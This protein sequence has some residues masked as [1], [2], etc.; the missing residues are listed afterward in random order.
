MAIDKIYMRRSAVRNI[1]LSAIGAYPKETTGLVLL[2]DLGDRNILLDDVLV[3]PGA[4][5]N[6]K[7]SSFSERHLKEVLKA[8][9]AGGHD[10]IRSFHS[11]TA[12]DGKRK[13]YLSDYPDDTGDIPYIQGYIKHVWDEEELESNPWIEFLLWIEGKS[14]KTRRKPYWSFSEKENGFSISVI[15]EQTGY[16]MLLRVFEF[17]DDGS[18]YFDHPME[19]V[20]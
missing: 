14:Y 11:H 15:T 7:E 8:L 19:L 3:I 1:A 17:Y 6:E 4:R 16:R 18:L 20:D 10:F 9:K 5:I 13:T 12:F 2:E